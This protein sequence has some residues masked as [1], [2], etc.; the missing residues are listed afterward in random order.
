[1]T[2]GHGQVL[3]PEGSLTLP[4]HYES[5]DQ[6]VRIPVDE[7]QQNLRDRD[8]TVRHRFFYRFS[9]FIFMRLEMIKTKA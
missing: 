6:L 5:R 2:N 7:R 8:I 9:N 1:M 3:P 4:N